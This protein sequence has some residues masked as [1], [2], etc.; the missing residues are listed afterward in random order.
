M[1]DNMSMYNLG[2][3]LGE[4]PDVELLP[5][6]E[7]PATVTRAEVKPSKSSGN[8]LLAITY[9]I[10]PDD[11]PPDFNLENAPDGLVL[12]HNRTVLTGIERDIR[13]LKRLQSFYK[14]H[15]LDPKGVKQ[16]DPTHFLGQKVM[17]K[18]KHGE[19]DG[20]TRE[21]IDAVNKYV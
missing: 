12:T 10:H 9:M 17:L 14:T 6:G 20:I 8:D 21:E 18:V 4:V 13:K 5:V 2:L 15:D 3:D 11:F 19:Y 1:S 16:I 7:Y